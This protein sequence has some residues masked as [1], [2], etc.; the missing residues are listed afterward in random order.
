MKIPIPNAELMVAAGYTPYH[1]GGGCMA[2]RK[3]I[4]RGYLLITTE[5][6][7]ID[8]N[9][10]DQIWMVGRYLE[11]GEEYGYITAAYWIG[12]DLQKAT[13]IGPEIPL[14][15]DGEERDDWI[16]SGVVP[17]PS[18]KKKARMNAYFCEGCDD[19]VGGVQT[20]RAQFVGK[21]QPEDVRYCSDCAGLARMNWNGVTKWIYLPEEVNN[22]ALR[23]IDLIRDDVRLGRIPATVATFSDLHDHVDAND[24]L[25][26][27]A[28]EEL[29]ERQSKNDFLEFNRVMEIV[30]QW[31]AV[32]GHRR[33]IHPTI[34]H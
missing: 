18:P 12:L 10:E 2:W 33:H 28:S 27:S 1:T 8:G 30:N 7:S 13:V 11:D 5:D 19:E 23:V 32:G 24:Y 4:D 3:D 22:M 31:L 9:A 15:K 21:Q 26:A 16:P 20:Y 14:P 17:D 6:A 34:T 29:T 25:G